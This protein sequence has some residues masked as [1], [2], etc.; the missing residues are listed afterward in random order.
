MTN[1]LGFFINPRYQRLIQFGVACLTFVLTLCLFLG[2]YASNIYGALDRLGAEALDNLEQP[3]RAAVHA[4][5]ILA[6]QPHDETCS[7]SM[8]SR[9][10]SVAFLPDGINEFLL[11]KDGAVLCSSGLGL[12][13]QPVA[14]GTVAMQSTEGDRLSYRFGENLAGI[15][16]TGQFATVVQ[17]GAFA[18]VLPKPD[19]PVFFPPWLEMEGV[20]WRGQG[21][22]YHMFGR[23]GLFLSYLKPQAGTASVASQLGLQQIRCSEGSFHC[24]A[25]GISSRQLLWTGAPWLLLAVTFSALVASFVAARVQAFVTQYFSFVARL[26]RNLVPER[27]ICTYQAIYDTR[28]GRISGCEVLVRWRDLDDRIVYPDRF[29]PIIEQDR[30]MMDLT[31]MVVD[32]AWR[33]LSEAI[34]P[35][36]PRL[37]I[38]FNISPRNLREP[39]LPILFD[40]FIA[41]SDRF[42]VA[43][44]IVENEKIEFEAAEQLIQRLRA[45]G[46]KTYIDDFGAG[47]SNMENLARLS[48]DAVKIDK[49]FALAPANSLMSEMLDFAVKMAQ[50]IGK[51]IVVEGVETAERMN[52]LLSAATPVNYIQG[53]YISRPVDVWSFAALLEAK[54][55]EMADTS[56]IPM[57]A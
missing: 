35:G 50:A 34:P 25:A 3:T 40:R 23:T 51:V 28:S 43:V 33:E 21:T 19:A 1:F 10:R 36:A 6:A 37:Q 20:A 30:R 44:E 2:F 55:A 18:A 46:I 11:M 24:V 42:S 32:R 49:S 38:N 5:E 29:L 45:R 16:H 8:E 13:P 15:G 4:F 56:A 27:V 39:D 12:L 26:R 53:Y 9:L 14:L 41:A 48:A 31:R 47:Y 52:H 7:D 17:S 54:S 57:S 22:P